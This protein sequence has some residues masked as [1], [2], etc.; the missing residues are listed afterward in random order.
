MIFF[1]N[2]FVALHLISVVPKVCPIFKHS[3]VVFGTNLF[4]GTSS[5]LQKYGWPNLEQQET[6]NVID[7]SI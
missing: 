7:F 6:L 1:K 4:F 3:D 2:S 5:L